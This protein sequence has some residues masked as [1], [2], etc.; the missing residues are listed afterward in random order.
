MLR[1]YSL[2]FPFVDDF[3]QILRIPHYVACEETLR[4]KLTYLFSLSSSLGLRH[5]VSPRLFKGT[6][7]EAS[8]FGS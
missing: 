4:R 5:C 7:S 1:R 3:V 8:I 2:N 6:Y